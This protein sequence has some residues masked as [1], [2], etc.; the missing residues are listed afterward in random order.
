MMRQRTFL[1]FAGAAC[2]LTLAV[3]P[4]AAQT[5]P[6]APAAQ[7]EVGLSAEM[8]EKLR[9]ITASAARASNLETP[10][11]K[12]LG[13]GKDGDT[14]SVKQFRAETTIGLYVFTLPVKPASDYVLFSFRDLSGATYTYLSDSQRQ[15]KAAMA[16]DSDGNRIL[17]NEDAAAGFRS[18]LTAWGEIAR[19]T[20]AP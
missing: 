9:R 2:A 1:G 17:P 16:S 8:L 11:M 7:G 14:I 20:K 6:P 10:V 19:R 3:T 12:M 13:L 4:A 18:I 5:S 15:L